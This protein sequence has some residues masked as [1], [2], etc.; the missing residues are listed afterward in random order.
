[1]EDLLA[2]AW[3]VAVSEARAV[4]T[5]VALTRDSRDCRVGRMSPRN[6]HHH[7]SHFGTHSFA[8]VAP[9]TLG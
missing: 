4:P 8:F 3:Y 1:M 5:V 7:H 9:Q 2:S 6:H